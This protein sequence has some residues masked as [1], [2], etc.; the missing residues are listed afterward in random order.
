M[1]IIALIAAG[2]V[3]SAPPSISTKAEMDAYLESARGGQPQLLVE[4]FG[5][6]E[7]FGT[8]LVWRSEAQ[9][10]GKIAMGGGIYDTRISPGPRVFEGMIHDC[11]L[12]VQVTRQNTIG[13]WKWE[14][15][16]KACDAHVVELVGRRAV[17]R[18]LFSAAAAGLRGRPIGQLTG[19]GAPQAVPASNGQ[20]LR[21]QW[22]DKWSCTMAVALNPEGLVKDARINGLTRECLKA[23]QK[24]DEASGVEQPAGAPK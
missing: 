10:Y 7:P 21:W 9:H 12:S 5:A 8:F 23:L 24:I 22:G 16:Q 18:D 14:G 15:E 3:A 20:V 11:A 4:A 13:R 19:L 1:P 2:A 17:D 6:P